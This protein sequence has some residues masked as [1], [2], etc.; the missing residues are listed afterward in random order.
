VGDHPQVTLIGTAG[1]LALFLSG[2]Q[3]AAR[4]EVTGPADL[5]E[6]VRTARLGI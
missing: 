3:R 6:R 4:V 1:E 2:R 5:A